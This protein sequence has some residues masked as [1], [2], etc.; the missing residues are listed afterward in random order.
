MIK[1]ALRGALSESVLRACKILNRKY[2]SSSARLS[3]PKSL[4]E[5]LGG[6]DVIAAFVTDYIMRIRADPKFARFGYGRGA[7][8]KMRDMQLNIDYMCKVAGGSN[9]YMGRDMKTT[10]AGLG[11]TEDEWKENMKYMAEALDK[12]KIPKR[13]KEEVLALVEHMRRDIVEK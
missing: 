7:D 9:Y 8:K 11:V 5:R 3:K 4:Y 6:Y 13:E 12:Y 10:H 2:N 1:G